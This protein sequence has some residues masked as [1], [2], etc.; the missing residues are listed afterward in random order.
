MPDDGLS[1]WAKS[2]AWLQAEALR[3]QENAARQKDDLQPSHGEAVTPATWALALL[4]R[5]ER[6]TGRDIHAV[7]KRL[8]TPKQTDI[9]G[10]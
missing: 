3:E 6:V 1:L 10:S 2:K 8:R 7:Y 9:N 4:Q 5:A